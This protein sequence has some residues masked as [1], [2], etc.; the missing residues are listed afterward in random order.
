MRKDIAH[1]WADA[2]EA[3]DRSQWGHRFLKYAVGDRL[4]V[5]PLGLL[6]DIVCG[7]M[8]IPPMWV[9]RPDP[10]NTIVHWLAPLVGTPECTVVTRDIAKHAECGQDPAF[11]NGGLPVSTMAAHG[12]HWHHIAKVV[13][14]HHDQL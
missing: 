14:Q 4:R 6:A 1:E 13:R 12:M 2:L 9:Q 5:S 7:R 10:S 11:N 3:T 8:R